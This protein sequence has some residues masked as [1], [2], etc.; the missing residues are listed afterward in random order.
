MQETASMQEKTSMQEISKPEKILSTRVKAAVSKIPPAE[1]PASLKIS[2]T[3]TL[4]KEMPI[5]NQ[6]CLK[7]TKVSEEAKSLHKL[8]TDTKIMFLEETQTLAS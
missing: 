1:N 6:N 7:L 8:M 3:I 4:L 5:I 2:S